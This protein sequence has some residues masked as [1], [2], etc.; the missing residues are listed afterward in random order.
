MQKQKSSSGIFY[1]FFVI[2][3]FIVVF[4]NRADAQYGERYFITAGL[5]TIDLIGDNIANE[6]VIPTDPDAQFAGGGFLGPQLGFNT[7]LTYL[8][9]KKGIFRVPLGFDIY[10]FDAVQRV[11]QSREIRYRIHHSLNVMSL[12]LGFNVAFLRFPLADAKAYIGIESRTA[13]IFGDQLDIHFIYS[14]PSR[15]DSIH[16]NPAKDDVFR[17]GGAARLGLEGKIYQRWYVNMSV[18]WGIM[19]I[20]GREEE[21]GEPL[22]RGELLTPVTGYDEYKENLVYTYHINFQVQYQL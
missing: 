8:L 3:F 21:T 19:N 11:P 16:T 1:K 14:D 13:F 18:A 7:T 2:V 10:F 17:L 20:F 9:D 6:P 5:S 22:E 15:Q 12:N 4:F